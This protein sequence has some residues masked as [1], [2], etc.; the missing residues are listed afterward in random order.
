MKYLKYSIIIIGL[1]ALVSC[2]DEWHEEQNHKLLMKNDWT[3]TMYVDGIK[4][5]VVTVEETKYRFESDGLLIKEIAD[6]TSETSTWEIPQRDY[7]RIGS[8]TFRI[9]TLTRRIMSLEYGEDVM[10]FLPETND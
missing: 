1:L 10:Y 2:T 3:L 6:N 4:N 7:V 5:E 9:R 8:A